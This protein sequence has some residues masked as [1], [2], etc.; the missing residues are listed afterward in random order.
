MNDIRLAA[1]QVVRYP[2]FSA[3]VIATLA[4]GIGACTLIFSAVNGV[5]LKP[6]PYPEPERIVRVRQIG[7][8]G[9]AADNISGPN[10]SDLQESARS[11]AALAR[12]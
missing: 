12:Y 5:L 6:L 11:F 9:I 4:L 2:G 1:R 3:V 10:F 8:T 7:R